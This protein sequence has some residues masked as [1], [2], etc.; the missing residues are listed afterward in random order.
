MGLKWVQLLYILCRQQLAM[1]A[2]SKDVRNGVNGHR[3]PLLRYMT[4]NSPESSVK[5]YTLLIRVMTWPQGCA[6]RAAGK[7]SPSS[8]SSKLSKQ[9][10]YESN[11]GDKTQ[12]KSRNN[13]AGARGDEGASGLGGRTG[14]LRNRA[15]AGHLGEGGR[16][17][18]LVSAR[19]LHG[20]VANL[21]SGGLGG[22]GLGGHGRRRKSGLDGAG[23]G[24]SLGGGG[25]GGGR[26]GGRRGRRSSGRAAAG[27]AGADGAREEQEEAEEQHREVGARGHHFD[28]CGDADATEKQEAQKSNATDRKRQE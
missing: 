15:T 4:P 3:F 19:L 1:P 10:T 9:R 22:H 16:E 5:S 6:F 18:G 23:R 7:V 17:V 14:G 27:V 28:G 8:L 25:G 21:V 13:S 24:S 2:V 26:G 12:S 20:L 11:G